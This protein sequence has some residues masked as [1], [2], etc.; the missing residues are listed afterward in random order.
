MGQVKEIAEKIKT[1]DP[2]MFIRKSISRALIERRKER[3]LTQTEVGA[4]VGCGKTTYATWEQCRSMPDVNTLYR[5]AQYYG[6]TMDEMYGLNRKE[7][8]Q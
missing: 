1:N 7:N 3:G 4:V 2:D 8:E 5:L 6:V